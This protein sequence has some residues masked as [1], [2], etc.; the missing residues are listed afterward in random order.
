MKVIDRIRIWHAPLQEHIARLEF[1]KPKL[2]KLQF[3]GPVGT[4]GKLGD[5]A[6]D[7]TENLAEILELEVPSHCWHTDR[8][9]IVEFCNWLSLVTGTLGK[10]GTDISLMAQQGIEEIKLA[11]GGGS[12]AMP[13]KQNPIKAET[14]TTLAVFNAT[15][16][17]GMHHTMI[18]EQ[19]RSGS[20][21][22]LEWMIVPQ[23]CVAAGASTRVALELIDSIK[24]IGSAHS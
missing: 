13:H 2:L 7:V 9:S 1:L 18:H 6:E 23:M 15:Q 4:L 16:V 10:M 8:S 24:E 19:E 20:T 5:K 14:L 3:G 22:A 21:W 17:S 11:G 12:S